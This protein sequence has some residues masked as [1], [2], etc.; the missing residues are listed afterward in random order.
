MKHDLLADM[1]SMIKNSEK[2]GRNECLV[3]VS[4]MISEVLAVMES[5]RYIGKFELV[6]GERGKNYRVELLGKI[7]NCNVVRPR[8]SVKKREFIKWEK[9]FLPASD[10]GLLILTTPKGVMDHKKAKKQGTGG[11]LLGFVY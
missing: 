6:P 8:F 3:Q 7:N 9:R 5:H 2:I 11:K 10:I 4:R 1:F